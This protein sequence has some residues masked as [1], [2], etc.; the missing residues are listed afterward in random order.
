[1][2]SYWYPGAIMGALSRACMVS[3]TAKVWPCKA[4]V[5]R[6]YRLPDWS[7]ELPARY[8]WFLR[9][10]FQSTLPLKVEQHRHDH[11]ATPTSCKFRKRPGGGSHR[12][13]RLADLKKFGKGE[14]LLRCAH[15]E[16]YPD[17]CEHDIARKRIGWNAANPPKQ[18][19]RS[20][21]RRA[22]AANFFAESLKNQGQAV[23]TFSRIM[24]KVPGQPRKLDP[25]GYT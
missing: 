12:G 6:E 16:C 11:S 7:K 8:K 9:I 22:H 17:Q 14:M 25:S 2:M 10:N 20:H 5:L 13:D 21:L 1:M 18:R 3:P 24:G 4:I 23:R 15:C 19:Y